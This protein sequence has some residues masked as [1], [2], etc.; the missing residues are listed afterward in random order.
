MLNWVVLPVTAVCLL[1][2]GLLVLRL[3]RPAIG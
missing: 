1:A 2:L 3:R